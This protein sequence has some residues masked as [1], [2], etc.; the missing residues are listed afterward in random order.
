MDP[1]GMRLFMLRLDAQYLLNYGTKWYEMFLDVLCVWK[2]RTPKTR[3]LMGNVMI[4]NEMCVYY[5]THKKI[6]MEH[7]IQKS[8]NLQCGA[9]KR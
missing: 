4:N 7:P 5:A 1:M 2:E 3:G 9:P 6:E 8:E